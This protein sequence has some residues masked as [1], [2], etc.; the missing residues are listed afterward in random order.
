MEKFVDS[1]TSPEQSTIVSQFHDVVFGLAYFYRQ[2]LLR[3]MHHNTG[4]YNVR[5]QKAF[6]HFVSLELVNCKTLL[7]SAFKPHGRRHEVEFADRHVFYVEIIRDSAAY[8][9]T[10]RRFL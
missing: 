9:L 10:V 4:E 5:I 7:L 6:Q 2:S 1:L 3:G 8:I